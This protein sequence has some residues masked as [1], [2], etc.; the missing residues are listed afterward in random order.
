MTY[1]PITW[2]ETVEASL[3]G[4]MLLLTPFYPDRQ[5]GAWN[6]FGMI[7]FYFLAR[8]ALAHLGLYEAVF[9]TGQLCAGIAVAHF[10]FNI[11][12]Y[13]RFVGCAFAS[14]TVAAGM[15]VGGFIP[16]R[17]FQGLGFDFWS[18]A[19]IASDIALVA[20]IIRLWIAAGVRENAGSVTKR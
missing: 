5:A 14:I 7:A 11:S 15:A 16:I 20:I 13:G 6:A 2:G 19:S 12:N 18:Y 8:I 9:W 17:L 1:W 3:L 10:A 4:V